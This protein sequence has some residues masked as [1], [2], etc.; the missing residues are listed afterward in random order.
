MFS[1][2]GSKSKIIH[3][4]PPPQYDTII[5]PF[6]G[7]ARYALKYW[8]RNIIINEKYEKVYRIWKYLQSCSYSDIISLPNMAEYKDDLRNYKL[9]NEERWLIG[10]CIA[11]GKSRPANIVQK[12]NSWANN[13]VKIAY[14][15]Y[16]IKFW[17]IRHGDYRD[18]ENLK[19]TWFIDPPYQYGGYDYTHS[20]L[21]ID[22]NNL[23]QWC[24]NR[25][26]QII[27]CEN[28]KA[29]WLDFKPMKKMQG[30]VYL[31]T[32]AIWTN[33]PTSYGIEQGS[34]FSIA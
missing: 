16:K 11:E 3:L 2:Y 20:S 13:K 31:T 27:V 34:L 29:D 23:S 6:A 21:S 24:K 33:Q 17:D 28:T 30:S 26:G 10:Y 15:L 9:C 5:E 1:Y 7:S 4:Y 8:D 18:I 14:N 22:F 32:E 12:R 19:A 25:Q